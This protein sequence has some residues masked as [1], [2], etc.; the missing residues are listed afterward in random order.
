[1][2]RTLFI[3]V[4]LATGFATLACASDEIDSRYFSRNTLYTMLN[5]KVVLVERDRPGMVTMDEWPQLV[6]LRADGEHKVADLI[7][8]I[9]TQYQGGPPPGLPE[10]TRRIVLDLVQ[11]GYL[12]LHKQKR[13][14]PYY[15]AIPVENQDKR[16]AKAVMEADGFIKKAAN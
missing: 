7:S 8:D 2:A 3:I 5:E 1:M 13:R 14:L 9:A 12:V 15:L 16:H 4:A 10:Q 6:F 11:R